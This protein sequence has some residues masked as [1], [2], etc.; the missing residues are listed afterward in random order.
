MSTEETTK[1]TIQR[2]R[3]GEREIVLLGT[4]HVSTESVRDVEQAI[5]QESPGRICVEIDE[6]RYR[7]MSESRSWSSLNIY[8]VLR[9][10]K[11]FMLLANLVLSSFQRKLGEDIGVKPGQEMQRAVEV[12]RERD[13]PFSLCDREIQV[14]LR[15]AWSMSG[16]WGKNKMLAALLGSVFSSEKL[17]SEQ[18]EEL[19]QK[20]A[21]QSM[22]E[23]LSEYLPSA[24]EV[25][26]D[27]RDRYLA[28]RIFQ[29][30]E[31][32]VLA[33]VGAG[34]MAGIVRWLYALH[35]GEVSADV[36]P[37]DRVP[38]PAK[39]T[40]ILPWLV[41]AAVLGLIVAGFFRSGWELTLS[42]LWMWVL[43]NGTLSA[44]GALIALAHPVTI[45][46]SFLAAPITS[47]NPTIGVGIV[48]GLLEAVLRKPR[49]AEFE[50]LPQDI[51][52]MRGFFRNRLTHVLLVFFFST[53]GSAIGT[54]LGIPFLTSLL[55]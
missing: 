39:V 16:F 51:V 47:M 46:V 54:F 27:E 18:I 25:L 36:Q 7:A 21:L 22:L 48:A 53:I 11:G 43:V 34:H 30:T 8:Q 3:L 41:P 1:E 35:A 17:T 55:A 19:K 37:I 49:V 13:I 5:E 45:V 9:D 32:K 33:V 6:G 29:T 38:A 2:V 52:T 20:N 50:R 14:T 15:R 12:A 10:R 31:Q 26:I 44:I 42:M 23:E 4:A 40:R 24:K 28:T